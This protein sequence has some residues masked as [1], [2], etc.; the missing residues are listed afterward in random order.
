MFEYRFNFLSNLIF[1]FIPFATNLLIWIAVYN[2]TGNGFGYSLKELI[3]YYFIILIVNN[4]IVN[5]V[6]GE[7]ASD[8]KQGTLNKYLLKP[9]SYMGYYFFKD[10]PNRIIYIVV[11]L[12]PITILGLLLNKYIVFSINLKTFLFFVFSLFIGYIINFLLSFLI[13]ECSF[14]FSEVTSFFPPINVLKD[15]ISGRV[16]PLNIIPKSL[17][18]V[19]LFTPFQ[20]TGYFQVMIILNRY[21]ESEIIQTLFLGLVWIVALY[22]L[23]KLLWRRGLNKYSAFGG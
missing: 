19:L 18:Q 7:V 6:Q 22:L 5:K 17:Y 11:G 8:I 23:C 13:S 16:F 1:S 2:S 21:S 3:T 9:L 10:L 20:F 4:L 12:L 15:I 14:Y